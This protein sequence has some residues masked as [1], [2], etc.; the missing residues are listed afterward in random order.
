MSN[1]IYYM[2]CFNYITTGNLVRRV[3]L[4]LRAWWGGLYGSITCTSS[5]AI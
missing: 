3:P 4:L 5:L 1:L 2:F